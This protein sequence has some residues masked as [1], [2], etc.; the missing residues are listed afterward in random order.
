MASRTTNCVVFL[1]GTTALLRFLRLWPSGLF[2]L[3]HLIWDMHTCSIVLLFVLFC[4]LGIFFFVCLFHCFRLK[5]DQMH[6]QTVGLERKDRI[7]TFLLFCD[8]WRAPGLF[9]SLLGSPSAVGN[10]P[11]PESFALLVFTISC[12]TTMSSLPRR[13]ALS[14][15]IAPRQSPPSL[16]VLCSLCLY[17]FLLPLKV[18]C[19]T[20]FWSFSFICH[21]VLQMTSVAVCNFR[22]F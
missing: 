3:S 20:T 11:P 15:L 2:M 9:F 21:S 19:P 1:L 17:N 4:F 10:S 14:T 13:F 8:P 7:K 12:C 6:C 5:Y 18:I 22:V 16:F